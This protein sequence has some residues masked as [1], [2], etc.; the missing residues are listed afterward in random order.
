MANKPLNWCLGPSTPNLLSPFQA[1]SPVVVAQ[2]AK[3]GLSAE[4]SS[5]IHA[6]KD[7][8]ELMLGRVRDP[9][10]FLFLESFLGINTL[11]FEPWRYSIQIMRVPNFI[12]L[13][14]YML[15]TWNRHLIGKT[16]NEAR[17]VKIKR[18]QLTSCGKFSASLSQTVCPHWRVLIVVG[19]RAGAWSGCPICSLAFFPVNV[20]MKWAFVPCPCA[21]WLRRLA[22]SLPHAARLWTAA[23]YP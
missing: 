8:I 23:V 20:Q 15:L 16:W 3:P 18:F 21:F 17:L 11:F 14:Q 6:L 9:D 10:L 4:P 5:L 19:A 22:R 2:N 12:G 13:V 1:A 7:L